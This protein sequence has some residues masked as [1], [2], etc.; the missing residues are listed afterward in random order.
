MKKQND[1]SDIPVAPSHRH[2]MSGEPIW[3][4]AAVRELIPIVTLEKTG[5]VGKSEAFPRLL[6]K[7]EGQEPV[8]IVKENPYCPEGT[9]DELDRYLPNGTKLYDRPAPQ[10]A[11]PAAP[12]DRAVLSE[13]S[14]AY[15]KE[16]GD[17]D[18][19]DGLWVFS[20][21]ALQHVLSCHGA[22]PAASVE[23]LRAAADALMTAYRAKYGRVHGF[24][25][26]NA[27]LRDEFTA[28][29]T[30]LY[31]APVAAQAQPV[32]DRQRMRA[33]V[34][35]VWNEAT[36]STT[37]P[38]TPWADRLIDKVFAAQAASEPEQCY[39]RIA[40]MK[41][42]N[43][44]SGFMCIDCGRLFSAA[45]V[46]DAAQAQQ[47][48]TDDALWDKTLRE[49]DDYHDMADQLAAQIAAITGAEIGE[50]SSA[51]DPW[52]NAMLAADEYIAVQ[53][54]KL[55][56]G[57]SAQDAI[58]PAPDEREALRESMEVIAT[59][60]ITGKP[61]EN[62]DAHNMAMVARAALST[63][64]GD[65]HSAWVEQACARIKAA[66]DAAS[67]NDYMLDS[68]DCIKVLRGEWNP[69][70]VLGEKP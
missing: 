29:S 47:R 6:D 18:E 12:Q 62:M 27:P 44:A 11:Q 59:W 50:H 13:V 58:K 15:L 26:L 28:L 68:D 10:A 70:A 41:N 16:W 53:L 22:Q 65:A 60:P 63:P 37:V 64:A 49:R 61:S 54:R 66:D 48:P 17:Y 56:S 23:P 43:V 25:K 57:R 20:D 39:H 67:L 52:R 55:C 7:S 33:L 24:I 21:T 46:T 3:N 45:P 69:G 35:L 36:E 8:A 2:P 40:D 38:D 42:E 4:E 30:A 32:P 14:R 51:N 9:S 31:A 5:S 1:I 34:D 19:A